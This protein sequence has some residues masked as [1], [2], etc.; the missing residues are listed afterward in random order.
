MKILLTGAAGF[1]GAAVMRKLASEGHDIVGI[2]NLNSYYDP[3]L[4]L[5]RLA[6]LGLDSKKAEAGETHCGPITF[7]KLDIT[8]ADAI[9]EMMKSGGFDKTVH[10]AAQAGVRYSLENPRAYV[11]TNVTGFLNILEGM[12]ASGCRHL[13]Y[14]SSSSVYGSNSKVPYAETDVTDS[15]VSL[16]AATKKTDELMAHAYYH[17]FGLHST[18]L[19]FF[20]VYGPWGR[21]DMAPMLFL[22]AIKA[23]RPIRLFNEGHMKRDFTYIDDVA[24]AVVAV[25]KAPA[26]EEPKIY[27]VGHCDPV[28]L[29]EFLAEM[30]RASGQKAMVE[31]APMQPGDVAATWADCSR[32]QAD[33]GVRPSKNLREGLQ[34]FCQWHANFIS[35]R[36]DKISDMPNNSSKTESYGKS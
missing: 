1:I 13:I 35:L 34:E 4:K 31:L 20:T 14:A 9:K 32:L 19:R 24:D 22:E 16:Y 36:S 6:S 27:N 11:E 33:F 26:P 12:R 23:G 17:T 29:P 2:D 18:G 21:P 25:V 15:P 10:L 3:R 30:E 7:L 28:D 8:D 5:A